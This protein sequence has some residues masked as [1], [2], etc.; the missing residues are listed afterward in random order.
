MYLVDPRCSDLVDWL[1][2]TLGFTADSLR[3][4]G[5]DL[6]THGRTC[7]K[8]MYGGLLVVMVSHRV[9]QAEIW[10]YGPALGDSCLAYC[11]LWTCIAEST[12]DGG[13]EVMHACHFTFVLSYFLYTCCSMHCM[14]DTPA[15]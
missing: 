4:S 12:R 10:T 6:A 11:V 5:F 7:D 2:L 3:G 14:R 9:D 15:F 1:R 13:F 8:K